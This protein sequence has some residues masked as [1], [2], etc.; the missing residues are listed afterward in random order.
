MFTIIGIKIRVPINLVLLK[1][2]RKAPII[3]AKPMNRI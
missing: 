3:S 2:S 1:N